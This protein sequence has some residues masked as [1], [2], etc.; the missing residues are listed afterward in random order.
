L[1]LTPDSKA[2]KLLLVSSSALAD[3]WTPSDTKREFA[4][5]GL[6]TIDALQTRNIAR[7]PDKWGEQ[8]NYLGAHPTVGAVDRYFIVGSVLHASV[9]YLLPEK[10]RAPFQYVA[11][12]IETGYV[13]S[14]LSLGIGAKL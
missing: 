2:L 1:A 7:H 9:S 13:A 12:G 10:Y 6:L 3:K 14:N 4:F 5:Q 11:I 8:N